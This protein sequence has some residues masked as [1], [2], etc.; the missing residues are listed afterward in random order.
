[1]GWAEYLP[2]APAGLTPSERLAWFR[3]QHPPN[4]S[5]VGC[6]SAYIALLTPPDAVRVAED[7]ERIA[8]ELPR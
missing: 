8:K 6:M 2:V 3:A 7:F 5:C 4:C 1:M